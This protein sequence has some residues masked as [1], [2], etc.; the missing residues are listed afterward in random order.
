M[1]VPGGGEPT[2]DPVVKDTAA[3]QSG[4]HG[5]SGISMPKAV[6]R[7]KSLFQAAAGNTGYVDLPTQ[8]ARR[9]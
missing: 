4:T 6:D 3:V 2:T 5:L 7:E 1:Q 8:P 9:C